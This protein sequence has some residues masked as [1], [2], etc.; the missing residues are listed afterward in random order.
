MRKPADREEGRFAGN[1]ARGSWCWRAFVVQRC[2]AP[3]RV[4]RVRT[5]GGSGARGWSHRAAGAAA[6]NVRSMFQCFT[7]NKTQKNLDMRGSASCRL[8]KQNS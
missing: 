7:L 2:G 8:K 5:G 6:R 3:V 4:G 1:A